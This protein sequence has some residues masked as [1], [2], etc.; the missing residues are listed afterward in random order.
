LR[1]GQ[2]IESNQVAATLKWPDRCPSPEQ[3]D[4]MNFLAPL[5]VAVLLA[6]SMVTPSLMSQAPASTDGNW[7][8]EIVTDQ[9]HLLLY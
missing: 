3:E 2:D 9:I 8:K 4:F 5:Q 6:T 1:E 7:P